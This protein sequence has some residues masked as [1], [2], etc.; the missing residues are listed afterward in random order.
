MLLN[1]NHPN[2]LLLE[3]LWL[4]VERLLLLLRITRI[5]LVVRVAYWLIERHLL[6]LN[7]I[8]L[9]RTVKWVQ[10]RLIHLL[11]S[12]IKE[13]LHFSL[14]PSNIIFFIYNNIAPYFLAELSAFAI[15]KLVESNIVAWLLRCNKI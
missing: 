4:L 7:W 15:G 11:V 14:K 13:L 12:W 10:L 2:R 3:W 8:L 1:W 9:H 6:L 5:V